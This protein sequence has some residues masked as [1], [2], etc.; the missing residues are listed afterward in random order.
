MRSTLKMFGLLAVGAALIALVALPGGAQPI[1]A[2][3]RAALTATAE[4]P[5]PQPTDTTQPLPQPTDT[6]QPL[7]QP[8]DTTQPLPQPTSTPI[9]EPT[10]TPTRRP[11]GDPEVADPAITK[12]ASPSEARI[13]DE[14][15][16]TLTVTNRGNV[17]AENVVVTDP[18][19]DFCDILDVSASRGDVAVSGNTVVVTL[20][21]VAPDEVISIQICTRVNERA[22]PPGGANMATL[23][24]SSPTDDPSNNT[25]T[26][27]IVI[28]VP[29]PTVTPVPAAPTTTPAPTQQPTPE[30]LPPTGEPGADAGVWLLALFSLGAIS[31]GLLICKPKVGR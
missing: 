21:A 20:G 8:T 13:G 29:A 22:Q 26:V 18:V 23:T 19:P 27:T 25:S 6:T 24:T 5:T 3:P 16:F 15:M 1:A 28:L 4:P 17:P 14:I 7:P 2:A 9:I 11:E 31:A 30:R 12:A 10:L